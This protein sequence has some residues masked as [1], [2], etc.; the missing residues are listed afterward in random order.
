MGGRPARV[1]V[2]GSDDRKD[3]AMIEATLEAERALAVGRLDQA[4]RLYRQIAA[5]EPQKATALVGLARV[6]LERDDDET[7][8]AFATRAL[9]VDPD[10]LAA[11]RLVELVPPSPLR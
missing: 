11:Q 2:P 7:C 1:T 8:R 10:N 9:E 3:V 4:E 5:S 6:A